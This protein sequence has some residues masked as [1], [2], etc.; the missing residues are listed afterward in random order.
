MPLHTLRPSSG[1][2][3]RAALGGVGAAAAALGL[4]T[5]SRVT[6]QEATPSAMAEHPI[7]GVWVF[8]NATVPPSPSTAIFAADGSVVVASAVN[9]QDAARGVVYA[10]DLIGTW[11]PT[12]P[13]SVH[14]TGI[15]IASDH[16]GGYTGTST[17]DGYQV[18][19][20]DGHTWTDDGTQ[21][22]LTIRDAANAV[23]TVL[24]G[25]GDQPPITPP[26]VATRMRPGPLTFPPMPKT[27][28]QFPGAAAAT[29]TP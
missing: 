14:L 6:A 16:N 9:Y 13:R 15:S 29:P 28:G 8:M 21:V 5:V 1:L 2:S 7:V 4:G 10:S 12:G 22:Q 11:E 17:L 20:A 25:G 27:S 23:V 19:S 26:V 24:G 18:V 3:R